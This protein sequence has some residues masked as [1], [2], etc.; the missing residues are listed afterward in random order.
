M[1]LEVVMQRQLEQRIRDLDAQDAVANRPAPSDF[2]ARR[3]T[4]YK[5]SRAE[6]ERRVTQ[7]KQKREGEILIV[8]V[9]REM[10][11]TVLVGILILLVM[12]VKGKCLRL[13]SMQFCF[14]NFENSLLTKLN[15]NLKNKHKKHP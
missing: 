13:D 9:R 10:R 15:A 14:P 12:V 8:S 2:Y 1:P 7:L 11:G 4:G 3:L 5:V 6:Q